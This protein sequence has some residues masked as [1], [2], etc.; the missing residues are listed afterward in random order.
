MNSFEVSLWNKKN[1]A[2]L[3]RRTKLLSILRQRRLYGSL[4]HMMRRHAVYLFQLHLSRVI[5]WPTKKP[6]RTTISFRWADQHRVGE[7]KKTPFYIWH[8]ELLTMKVG[9]RIEYFQTN[10]LN[11]S[12]CRPTKRMMRTQ[13]ETTKQIYEAADAEVDSFSISFLQQQRL[14]SVRCIDVALIKAL[15]T[16]LMTCKTIA[17]KTTELSFQIHLLMSRG[18][19]ENSVVMSTW[20]SGVPYRPSPTIIAV[21]LFTVIPTCSFERFWQPLCDGHGI[22][23]CLAWTPTSLNMVKREFPA[24]QYCL[25]LRSNPRYVS[26]VLPLYDET[27]FVSTSI[28]RSDQVKDPWYDCANSQCSIL[29]PTFSITLIYRLSIIPFHVA[30]CHSQRQACLYLLFTIST[31]SDGFW[32]VGLVLLLFEMWSSRIPG[33]F[34][35]AIRR[36]RVV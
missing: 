19:F 16:S 6:N 9:N 14:W 24:F 3:C 27:S 29:E 30:R 23:S 12:P 18:V 13:M 2:N 11:N 10:I 4:L 7:K 28:L 32:G 20:V 25:K 36:L 1:K 15:S 22:L 5:G 21:I 17:R 33:L 34:G 35:F 8:R 26:I 31:C